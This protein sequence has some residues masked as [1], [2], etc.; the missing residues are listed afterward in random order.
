MIQ[1]ASQIVDGISQH[2]TQQLWDGR[3]ALNVI[4]DLSRLTV[5]FSRPMAWG[6]L[7]RKEFNSSLQNHGRAFGPNRILLT[8]VDSRYS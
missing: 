8:R 3:D 4:D 1:S 5:V 6:L 2:E 7:S